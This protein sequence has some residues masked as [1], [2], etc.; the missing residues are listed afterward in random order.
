M[1]EVKKKQLC[2]NINPHVKKKAKKKCI[3]E[4]TTLS[5][6]I[7]EFLRKWTDGHI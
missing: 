7:E 1:S 4:G 3:D 5:E 6:K 2:I